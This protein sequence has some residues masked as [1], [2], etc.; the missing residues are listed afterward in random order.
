MYVHHSTDTVAETVGVLGNVDASYWLA[1][2][3][4][5]RLGDPCGE[6]MAES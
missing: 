3:G 6:G 2:L 1:G 5:C 4:S